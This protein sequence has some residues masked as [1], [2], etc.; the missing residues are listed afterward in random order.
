M[1]AP[2][3]VAQGGDLAQMSRLFPATNPHG[4][5]EN[6]GHAMG[7][8]PVSANCN[9]WARRIRT[10]QK[11]ET[12]DR[13][14]HKGWA[15][16]YRHGFLYNVLLFSDMH[17]VLSQASHRPLAPDI[18]LSSLFLRSKG[19]WRDLTCVHVHDYFDP[20]QSFA[21]DNCG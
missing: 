15:R 20:R 8:Q 9:H 12:W 14:C 2:C 1:F 13:R 16:F 6:S 3:A 19:W 5:R 21:G 17:A 11:V 4:R 10:R 7:T 18:D